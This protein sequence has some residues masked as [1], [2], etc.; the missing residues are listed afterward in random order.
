MVSMVSG[1]SGDDRLPVRRRR[2][3]GIDADDAAVRRVV[4][5]EDEQLA[6]HAFEHVVGVV[7]DR[8]ESAA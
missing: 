1:F 3:R 2:I 4:V 8:R 6:A 7:A 5:G